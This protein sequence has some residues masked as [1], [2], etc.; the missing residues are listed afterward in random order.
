MMS[1]KRIPAELMPC[2]LLRTI[3]LFVN[4]LVASDQIQFQVLSVFPLMD[5]HQIPVI[6]Q[7][8]VR[9]LLLVTRASVLRIMLA[10]PSQQAVVQKEHAQLETGTV[11]HTQLAL[12]VGVLIPA[13]Q[14]VVQTLCVQLLTER[15]SVIVRRGLRLP[16]R[17]LAMD[18]SVK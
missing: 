2:A 13:S 6:L 7:P 15:L 5:A 17:A 8:S 3:E 18:A 16:S 12:V 4:V 10:I 1:A 11:L 14:L 9:S